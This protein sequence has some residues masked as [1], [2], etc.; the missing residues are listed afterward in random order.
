MESKDLL[1]TNN[2]Y[3]DLL[4]SLANHEKNI[5][6]TKIIDIENFEFN[7]KEELETVKYFIRVLAEEELLE[8]VFHSKEPIFP[9]EA[10]EKVFKL[11]GSGKSFIFDWNYENPYKDN[12]FKD[13][14]QIIH[15]NKDLGI[16][17]ILQGDDV[18][19]RTYNVV[20]LYMK[21]NETDFDVSSLRKKINDG[22]YK[23][24]LVR[25]SE[26]YGKR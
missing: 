22:S 12:R 21:E 10:H 25:K 4:C 18:L 16:N 20:N 6:L 1:K 3:F 2:K 15:P 7:A 24:T 23:R 14:F 9:E 17:V 19:E 11:Y 26:T 13:N 5:Y 8:T